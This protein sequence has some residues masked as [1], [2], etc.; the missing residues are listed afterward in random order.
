MNA[1]R[2]RFGET[3]DTE[4]HFTGSPGRESVSSSDRIN[5]PGRVE[6]NADYRDVRVRYVLATTSPIPPGRF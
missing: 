5:L 3:Q 2:L 1:D 6:S 4:V